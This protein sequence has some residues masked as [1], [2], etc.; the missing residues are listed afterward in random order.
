MLEE[1]ISRV[2]DKLLHLL[3]IGGQQTELRERLCGPRAAR[4]PCGQASGRPGRQSEHSAPVSGCR[5][6]RP[7]P[8][9]CRTPRR[10]PAQS[11]GQRAGGLPRAGAARPPRRSPGRR[12]PARPTPS[13]DDVRGQRHRGLSAEAAE[14]LRDGLFTTKKDGTG[15]GPLGNAQSAFGNGR[16]APAGRT[17]P[18]VTERC[19]ASCCRCAWKRTPAA[20]ARRTTSGRTHERNHSPRRRRTGHPYR[21]G[22]FAP[23]RRVQRHHRGL[24]GGSPAAFRGTAH[25]HRDH[26]HQDARHE[27][28]GS[29]SSTSRSSRRK[30]KSSSFP[31]M[32]IWKRRFRGSSW[33]RPTPPPNPSTTIC[34]TFP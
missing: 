29:P 26:R 11:G 31:D 23:R 32:R 3:R 17:C 33:K 21:H 28:A 27:R 8:S 15:F 2:R 34:C 14:R 10:L 6:F 12:S 24:G 25:P 22:S 4:P 19:S 9:G 5:R 13:S 30:P 16:P 18:T 1:D 20:A 7:H